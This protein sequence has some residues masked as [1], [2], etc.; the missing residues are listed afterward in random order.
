MVSRRLLTLQQV[1]ARREERNHNGIEIGDAYL[2]PRAQQ[3]RPHAGRRCGSYDCRVRRRCDH[4]PL[5][6]KSRAQPPGAARRSSP[7]PDEHYANYAEADGR[8]FVTEV[9][10]LMTVTGVAAISEAS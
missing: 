8:V 1:A 7:R 6:S 3:A 9:T 2:R 4:C 10:S 5:A